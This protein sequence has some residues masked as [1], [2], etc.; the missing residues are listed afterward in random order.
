VNIV[1]GLKL[2][3]VGEESGDP[4][5]WD[6][7]PDRSLVLAHD[8]E[9]ARRLVGNGAPVAEVMGET[10]CVLMRQEWTDRM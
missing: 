2:F 7:Y 8:A 4:S 3:V 5:L 9:E 1:G 10:P 6:T